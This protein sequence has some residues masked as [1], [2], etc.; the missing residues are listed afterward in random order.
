MARSAQAKPSMNHTP[1]RSGSPNAHVVNP[2]RLPWRKRLRRLTPAGIEKVSDW[3]MADLPRFDRPR[4]I[5]APP[6]VDLLETPGFSE[7]LDEPLWADDRPLGD[8]M[9]F[10][11]MMEECVGR[12]TLLRLREDVGF[13]TAATLMFIDALYPVRPDN[14]RPARSAEHTSELQSLMRISYAVFC[15]K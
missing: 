1:A 8:A 14:N 10:A 9:D 3:L 5:T 4:D 6:P 7:P 12:E 2:K 11:V 15:L 13:W